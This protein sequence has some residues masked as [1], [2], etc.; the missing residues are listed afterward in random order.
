MQ[1]VLIL[2][3]LVCGLSSAAF[4]DVE[5]KDSRLQTDNEVC[6]PGGILGFG[7]EFGAF[8]E[9]KQMVDY[10]LAIGI[11]RFGYSHSNGDMSVSVW[12]FYIKP[13]V[14]SITV[15]QFVFE[16]NFGFGFILSMNN[17]NREMEDVVKNGYDNWGFLQ[18][19]GHRSNF[20]YGYRLGYRITEQM[21]VS[22][23]ANYQY[24]WCGW[25]GSS[26]V[27]RH[28]FTGGWGLNFQWNIPWIPF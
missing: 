10:T 9:P 23:V 5:F 1:R 20:R 4:L 28:M 2:I 22:L 6:E 19:L 11:S 24:I 27:G 12:D 17:F 25:Y 15:R 26:S 21:Q 7:I 18:Y 3:L 14:W 16:I 8:N 13:L